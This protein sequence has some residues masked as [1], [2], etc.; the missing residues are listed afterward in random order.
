MTTRTKNKFAYTT[1]T[2]VHSSCWDTENSALRD[3]DQPIFSM[4]VI[5]GVLCVPG[6]LWKFGQGLLPRVCVHVCVSVG[7]RGHSPRSNKP[8]WPR[9]PG[10]AKLLPGIT[11]PPLSC[12]YGL[13]RGVSEILP[14]VPPYGSGGVGIVYNYFSD[15]LCPLPGS[16]GSPYP[17]GVWCGFWRA[18]WE[19]FRQGFPPMGR[20]GGEDGLGDSR[21]I[22]RASWVT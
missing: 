13:W 16:A 20:G 19:K 18:V 4:F 5:P 15:N 17:L 21:Q 1:P 12:W 3:R 6:S 2:Q 9:L 22:G 10:W 14:G 7:L 11:L 8:P